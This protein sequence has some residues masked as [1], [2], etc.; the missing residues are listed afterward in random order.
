MK[1]LAQHP[2]TGPNALHPDRISAHERRTEFYGLVAS[3]VMRL[4]QRDRGHVSRID[5]DISLHFQP[6]QSGTA[7]P[8]QR[9]SA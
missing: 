4:L 8:T 3:A 5:G 1:T 2:T 6:E 7:G 9:R